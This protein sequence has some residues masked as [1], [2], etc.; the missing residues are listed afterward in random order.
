[1]CVVRSQLSAVQALLSSHCVSLVHCTQPPW[2]G[3]QVSP[4]PQA[5]LFGV[6]VHWPAEHVS[7]VQAI[8]SSQSVSAQHE[9]Q[10][11]AAQHFPPFTQVLNEQLPLTQVPL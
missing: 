3:S 1:L 5:V 11:A 9:L 8:R 10:P 7:V 6:C 4:T 2:A